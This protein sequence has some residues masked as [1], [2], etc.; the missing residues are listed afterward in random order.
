MI[1]F[2][3]DVHKD[4][5]TVAGRRIMGSALEAQHTLGGAG[6][7]RIHSRPGE[8]LE[9]QVATVPFPTEIY[10][11]P[12]GLRQGPLARR[13]FAPHSDQELR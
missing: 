7:G 10:Q 8:T 2:G 4:S 11:L 1:D 3:P 13:Y 6:A 5:S 12:R 9:P